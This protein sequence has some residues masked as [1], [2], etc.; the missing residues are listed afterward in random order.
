M[1][2]IMIDFLTVGFT[3]FTT[4]AKTSSSAA[5]PACGRA[6]PITST[7]RITPSTS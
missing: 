3:A 1:P 5:T 6:S 2:I 4:L 7:S